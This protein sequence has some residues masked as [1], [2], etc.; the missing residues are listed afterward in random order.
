M[1]KIIKFT[2]HYDFVQAA[3]DFIQDKIQDAYTEY[4][5]ARIVLS[6][7]STPLPVYAHLAV[8]D[9]LPWDRVQLFQ[10]DERYLPANSKHSNQYQLLQSF[11]DRLGYL[12][13]T[14]FF[15]VS[16][17]FEDSAQRYDELI[18]SLDN[19]EF[20]FDLT[21]L[22]MGVDGHTASLFPR[23]PAL[24]AVD[25]SAVATIVPDQE[26]TER[27]TLT[28][29]AILQSKHIILLLRGDDKI[30]T[31]DQAL[32]EQISYQDYPIRRI[33]DN[34]QNVTIFVLG[35]ESQE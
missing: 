7:G 20:L 4:S 14:H 27:L 16:L 34:H 21:V 19:E 8:D 31:L 29:E 30:K 24:S 23:N 32:Q 5:L 35:D 25:R 15:D 17:P 22:G 18:G 13:G 9:E 11:G 6:G 2:N 26:F 1:S 10:A 33:I 3:S 12:Y 28:Y